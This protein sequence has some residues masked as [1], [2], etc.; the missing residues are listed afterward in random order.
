MRR[1]VMKACPLIL[2]SAFI[3][4]SCGQSQGEATITAAAV[5][6]QNDRLVVTWAAT[7]KTSVDVYLGADP[8]APVSAMRLIAED[9]SGPPLSYAPT[10]VARPYLAITVHGKQ[11]GIR[12]AE[13]LLPLQG[14]RNFRD[15]GGYE[16]GDGRRMRWGV[17]YR[18]GTMHDLTEADYTYLSRLG[19]RVVCD[20]RSTAERAK[21]PTRWGGPTLPAFLSADYEA[22]ARS[23]PSVIEAGPSA[24]A[25]MARAKMIEVYKAI[26]TYFEEAFSQAFKYLASGQVPLVFHC[27][28]GKDR[29]GILSAL[30]L[31]ALGVPWETVMADYMLSERYV[32]Y[33]ALLV[34]SPPDNPSTPKFM[35]LKRDVRAAILRVDPQYLDAAFSEIRAAHGSVD[36]YLQ[37]VLGLSSEQLAQ[38]RNSLTEK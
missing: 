36:G 4:A 28:A 14:G 25:E 11:E 29:T 10:D 26:P 8:L 15:L 7:P 17:L 38:V 6:R 21:E 1:H 22:D 24:T 13:R 35:K 3:L 5:E 37:R 9:L 34:E 20:L 19:I 16:T 18:S 30:I 27:S 32:D 2:L 12:V 23:I 33:S 31:S